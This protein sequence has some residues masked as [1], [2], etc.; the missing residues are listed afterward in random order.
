MQDVANL[1]ETFFLLREYININTF[2]PTKK[3]K[4]ISFLSYYYFFL[5]F[6]RIWCFLQMS[7]HRIF[8]LEMWY[9]YKRLKES[10]HRI[11]MLEMWYTYKRLKRISF[12]FEKN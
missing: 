9:T 10:Y 5:I 4:T 12:L 11:F 8:M 1:L 3:K 6:N 2:S 7:Y